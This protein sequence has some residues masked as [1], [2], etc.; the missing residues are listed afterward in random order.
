MRPAG[1]VVSQLYSDHQLWPQ[2][3][4]Q[5]WFTKVY[6][7]Y[8]CNRITRCFWKAVLPGPTGPESE[9]P[10]EWVEQVGLRS[11][12]W[13]PGF[14]I[15]TSHLSFTFYPFLRSF[16]CISLFSVKMQVLSSFCRW[17]G[18]VPLMCLLVNLEPGLR[19]KGRT[20][21]I[22]PLTPPHDL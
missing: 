17:G 20:S 11:T 18:E 6:Q 13:L 7:T 5:T 15:A 9:F 22:S 19:L 8:L 10:D 14:L 21:S 12:S 2:Q 4:S 16:M 1:E 3:S